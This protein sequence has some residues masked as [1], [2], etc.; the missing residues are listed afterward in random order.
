[1]GVLAQKDTFGASPFTK[2]THLKNPLAFVNLTNLH[3]RSASLHYQQ[4]SPNLHNRSTNSKKSIMIIM[5]AVLFVLLRLQ[6]SL[7]LLEPGFY[8]LSGFLDLKNLNLKHSE[9]I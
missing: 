4:G 9:K 5:K 6:K 3:N 1:M 7:F 8:Y 2:E